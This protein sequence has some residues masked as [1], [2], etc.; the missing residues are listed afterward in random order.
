VKDRPLYLVDER[1]G[2]E[3][4]DRELRIAESEQRVRERA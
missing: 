4:V 1:I 2:G 3:A